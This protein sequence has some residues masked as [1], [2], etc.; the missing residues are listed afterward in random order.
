MEVGQNSTVNTADIP[1]FPLYVTDQGY[2]ICL[3]SSEIIKTILIILLVLSKFDRKN[4]FFQI[5]YFKL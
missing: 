4:I 3:F 1:L 2:C 5:K